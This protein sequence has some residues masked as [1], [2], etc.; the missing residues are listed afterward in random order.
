MKTKSLTAPDPQPGELWEFPLPAPGLVGW[1]VVKHHPDDPRQLFV[2]PADSEDFVGS[3]D[4][5]APVLYAGERHERVVLRGAFGRWLTADDFWFQV[6]GA[7]VERTWRREFLGR[8]VGAFQQR[9]G[10]VEAEP[11]VPGAYEEWIEAVLEPATRR[12]E[13]WTER[14][15]PDVRAE[16]RADPGAT[17]SPFEHLG[18]AAASSGLDELLGQEGDFED[19][20]ERELFGLVAGARVFLQQYAGEAALEIYAAPSGGPGPPRMFV[21]QKSTRLYLDFSPRITGGWRS[22]L[23]PLEAPSLRLVV[24]GPPVLDVEL[25]LESD[26]GSSSE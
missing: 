25:D 12:L 14:Q 26:G 21:L 22:Q 19:C 9:H 4:L 24:E 17:T 16:E 3:V 2:V 10:Q 5:A 23:F 7:R 15:V 11:S 20:V 6:P 1:V 8:L 18:L 13:S